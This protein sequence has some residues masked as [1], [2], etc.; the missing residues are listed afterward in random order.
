M[1]A[2]TASLTDSATMFQRNF[3]HTVR[4][5]MTLFSAILFPIIMMFLFVY[6]FGGAFSVGVNY[7][8]YATPGLIMMT[9]GYGVGPTAVSVHADMATGIINRLRIMDV[10][11]TAVLGAH[12]IASMLRS[13]AAIVFII[14]FALVM[15]FRPAAS[16]PEWL[17]VIGIIVLTL[18]AIGWLTVAL[19][20]AAKTPETANFGIIPLVLLPF[21]SSAFVPADKMGAG[22]RQFAEYQPFTPIIETLRGLLAGTPS[23]GPAIAAIAWC[24]GLMLI[25]YLWA[26]RKFTKRG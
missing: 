4:N 15:G 17:G 13:L 20:L 6:V 7:V 2:I 23:A 10:S 24:V 11:R 26:R 5:P 16:F 1:N 22:V 14:A 3:R 18:L 12:V 8:D 21:L 19:G 9:I 25:G